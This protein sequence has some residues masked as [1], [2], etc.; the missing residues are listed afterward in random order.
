MPRGFGRLHLPRRRARPDQVADDDG[1]VQTALFDPDDAPIGP[2]VLLPAAII[3]ELL[4]DAVDYTPVWA[5]PRPVAEAAAAE[6]AAGEPAATAPAAATDEPKPTKRPR[7][8][9]ANETSTASK[10]RATS[11]RTRKPRSPKP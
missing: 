5:R 10:P 9:K 4:F 7:R 3:Q 11:T 6:P 2:P 1:A 8:P